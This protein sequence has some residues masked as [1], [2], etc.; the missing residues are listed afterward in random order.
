MAW[1]TFL[2]QASSGAV[3]RQRVGVAVRCRSQTGSAVSLRPIQIA[4][5]YNPDTWKATTVGPY[6]PP[7][8]G[9]QRRITHRVLLREFTGWPDKGPVA[10][11]LPAW[12]LDHLLADRRF[13]PDG[14]ILRPGRGCGS[15][16]LR[17]RAAFA[18]YGCRARGIVRRWRAPP[19]VSYYTTLFADA[20]PQVPTPA[21]GFPGPRAH[22][23]PSKTL[24]FSTLRPVVHR[25]ASTGECTG[26]VLAALG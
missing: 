11:V 23:Q 21:A 13:E 20:Q 14:K 15:P 22:S 26:A 17:V 12:R 8:T 5:Q 19:I 6:N 25:P 3:Y 10:S 24:D 2:L 9:W 18:P 7:D 16:A 4:A 1:R